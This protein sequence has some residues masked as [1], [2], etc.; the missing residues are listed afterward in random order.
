MHHTLQKFDAFFPKVSYPTCTLFEHHT[1]NQIK[2]QIVNIL[3]LLFLQNDLLNMLFTL[4][5]L[6]SIKNVIIYLI[7]QLIKKINEINFLYEFI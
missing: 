1:V 3:Q 7:Q 5:M 2:A 6:I 4:S